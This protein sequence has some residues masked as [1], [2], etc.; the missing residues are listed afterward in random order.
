MRMDSNQKKRKVWRDT[1]A[2]FYK[3]IRH[4]HEIGS[5]I[6]SSEALATAMTCCLRSTNVTRVAELGAGTG[7][8]TRHIMG[9]PQLVKALIFEKDPDMRAVLCQQYSKAVCEE[10]ATQLTRIMKREGLKELDAVISGLPFAMFT[11]ELRKRILD[12]VDAALAI[13]GLFI[14]FQYSLQMKAMLAERFDMERIRFVL[15][16]FPPAFVYC[17]RKRR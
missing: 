5:L 14:T 16:N 2:F 13:D 3:F 4:P 9:Q 11:V 17:C 8:F 15:W 1:V 10:D 7:V 12:E 6:P